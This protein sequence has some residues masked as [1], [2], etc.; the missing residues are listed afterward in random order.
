[1]FAASLF[2]VVFLRDWSPKVQKTKTTTSLSMEVRRG[3]EEHGVP[4][5]P[6]GSVREAARSGVSLPP[7]RPLVAERPMT[8]EVTAL[9]ET[10]VRVEWDDGQA[11]ALLLRR[12]E[13]RQWQARERFVLT[14]GNVTGTRLFLDGRP[15]A[16]PRSKS[17]T[18]HNVVLSRHHLAIA[19]P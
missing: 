19:L 17:N 2:Y 8:L 3:P 12:G 6:V 13:R 14:I 9:G 16:L 18:L 4:R 15:V 5:T 7:A 1:L 10:W 11:S